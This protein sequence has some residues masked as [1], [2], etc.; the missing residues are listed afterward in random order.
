MKETREKSTL[1]RDM[2]GNR[3][4]GSKKKNDSGFLMVSAANWWTVEHVFK[5]PKEKHCQS[6]IF[7][8]VKIPLGN[9]GEVLFQAYES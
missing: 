6:R 8:T 1:Q 5:V 3:R 9:E 4:W 2:Q 7:Y